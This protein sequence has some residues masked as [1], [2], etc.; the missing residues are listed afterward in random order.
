M[1]EV[2]KIVLTGGPCAGKSTA[3][4]YVSQQLDKRNIKNIVIDERATKLFLSGKSPKNMGNYDFHKLLFKEQLDEEMEKYEY[5]SALPYDKVV[6]ISDRGLLDNRAYVTQ[7]EFDRYTALYG[8]NE[9]VL[10]N[11]YDA[12]FHLVTAAK[13]ADKHYTLDNNCV[14]SESID[15]AVRLDE[16]I[17]A[18]WTGTPHL[19]V[20]DNSTDFE[21]KL[22]RLMTEILGFL[23][24]P[25]PFE[26]ERKFL[27]EYPNLD[28]INKLK[29]CRRVPITQAYLTTPKDGN[30]RI[31]KRGEGD[32]AV[33][34]K[35]VKIKIN[36]IKR[37]E[38]ENYIS[39]KEYYEIL[40]QSDCVQGII[41]KD[42]Y[43][44][45]YDNTYYELDVYPFWNDKATLEIELLGENQSYT[46]PPFARLIREVS[47]ESEY[48]N[49]ALAQKY[50]QKHL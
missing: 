14:R 47:F 22:S 40:S 43:C 29:T 21:H 16:D 48:R 31:R 20:I 49:F 17:L 50:G 9:D 4:R 8:T 28:E 37:I 39:E 12:V 2:I 45:M 32:R 18:I 26:I 33:Y 35:T 25:E 5:A 41:S 23:G 6:I 27:I 44:I 11:S 30:F 15:E 24:E 42:R 46:L 38:I 36:D 19:R 10:R 3:V 13:G 1:A 7:A 34:I